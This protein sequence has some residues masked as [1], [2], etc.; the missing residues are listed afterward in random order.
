MK[1]AY[2]L[3]SAMLVAFGVAAVLGWYLLAPIAIPLAAAPPDQEDPAPRIVGG[4][5]ALA[6][7]YPWITALVANNATPAWYDPQPHPDQPALASTHPHHKHVLPDIKHHRVPA[8][9]LR[10]DGPNL[11]LLIEEVEHLLLANN[12]DVWPQP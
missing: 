5:E 3:L 2:S 7:A 6:G 1:R 9:G 12:A 10:F 11:P 8:P 4:V